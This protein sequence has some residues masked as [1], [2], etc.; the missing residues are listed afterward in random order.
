MTG[1]PDRPSK[2]REKRHLRACASQSWGTEGRSLGCGHAMLPATRATF[3]E[4]SIVAGTVLRPLSLLVLHKREDG[5][6]VSRS[7][8]VRGSPAV[9][10]WPECLRKAASRISWGRAGVL[11][12]GTLLLTGCASNELD[13]KCSQ[14]VAR[15]DC[16]PGTPA[17]IES[18]YGHDISGMDEQRCLAYGPAGSEAYLKCREDFA[19]DRGGM[20][21]PSQ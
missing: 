11:L 3:I 5:E 7:V 8:S 13:D 17:R 16:P 20:V 19:R 21:A 15:A 14:A 6:M 18:D 10:Y 4:A 12:I 9:G 2:F 1:R